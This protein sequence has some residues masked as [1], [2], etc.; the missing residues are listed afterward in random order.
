MQIFSFTGFFA[1]G[2]CIGSPV[3]PLLGFTLFLTTAILEWSPIQVLTVAQVAQ[4]QRSCQN[5]CFHLGIAH[6]IKR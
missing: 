2:A 3:S 1:L 6:R 5:W 4:L